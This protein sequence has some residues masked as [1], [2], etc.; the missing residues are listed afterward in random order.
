[1]K[2]LVMTNAD[3]RFYP[4][5]QSMLASRTIA[6]ELDAPGQLRDLPGKRWWIAASWV[7]L[8]EVEPV[9]FCA[10][11]AEDSGVIFENDWVVAS[12]R[13]RGIYRQLFAVRL[14]AYPSETIR[15]YCADASLPVYLGA[16]FHALEDGISAAGHHWTLVTRPGR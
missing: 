13:R 15:A 14:G 2:I 11:V 8:I 1:M 12:H 9:G 16:G 10:A 3:P 6:G 5:M 7:G 4:S